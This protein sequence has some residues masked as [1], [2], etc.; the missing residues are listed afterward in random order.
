MPS[1][2]VTTFEKLKER[3]KS[4]Q[5]LWS[6]MLTRGM[7]WDNVWDVFT[8]GAAVGGSSYGD[9]DSDMVPNADMLFSL[10]GSP[11]NVQELFSRMASIQA[12]YPHKGSG[13]YQVWQ[14]NS[15]N[16]EL[17][18]KSKGYLQC[19]WPQIKSILDSTRALSD[20]KQRGD[21][22][23]LI[24]HF[25]EDKP[26]L[27]DKALLHMVQT[28]HEFVGSYDF[29]LLARECKGETI[30][31]LWDAMRMQVWETPENTEEFMTVFFHQKH[32]YN[33]PVEQSMAFIEKHPEAIPGMLRAIQSYALHNSEDQAFF[34]SA[35]ALLGGQ[36]DALV[37]LYATMGKDISLTALQE[38]NANLQPGLLQMK[39]IVQAYLLLP[40]NERDTP[41][42]QAYF[43]NIFQR[44]AIDMEG[45]ANGHCNKLMAQSIQ[46]NPTGVMA[47]ILALH[48]CRVG[49][50]PDKCRDDEIK[51]IKTLFHHDPRSKTGHASIIRKVIPDFKEWFSM[52]QG[53][54][55]D[56][57]EIWEHGLQKMALNTPDVGMQVDGAV[58]DDVVL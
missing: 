21:L 16:E 46:S 27:R 8:R 28:Q 5:W 31:A 45:Y 51:E 47:R 29:V 30:A 17:I 53:L 52:V 39:P 32:G 26:S 22:K 54:G 6:M 33:M 14:A 48:V 25:C 9:K 37:D 7:N 13:G 20:D 11:T 36:P 40:A 2:I 15:L 23:Q 43:A 55:L 57:S 1:A 19:T 50:F 41:E 34:E 3:N 49:L 12:N 42:A 24:K 56:R 35:R 4:P 38:A 44:V 10:P 58:F 18:K